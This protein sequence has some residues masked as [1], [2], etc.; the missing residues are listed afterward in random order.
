M[1]QTAFDFNALP[2]TSSKAP[3][4]IQ[5]KFEEFDKKH[6]EVWDL[7]V[8]FANELWNAGRTRYSARTII[9]RI[10]W[11]YDVN[12]QLDGGFKINNN[13]SSR[14]ARK[15]AEQQSDKFGSFFEL[16]ELKS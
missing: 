2:E 11:H 1:E 10:R 7:F 13:F 3:K 12:K 5:E 14:Y 15:L 6:P 8:R 9:H 4:T 16:R